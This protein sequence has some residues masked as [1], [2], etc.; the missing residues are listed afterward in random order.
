MRIIC[1]KYSNISRVGTEK[2]VKEAGNFSTDF[3]TA[4]TMHITAVYMQWPIDGRTMQL[5]ELF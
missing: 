5:L 1:D 3:P 4:Y 2:F